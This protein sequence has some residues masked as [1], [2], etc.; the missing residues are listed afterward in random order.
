MSFHAYQIFL[1]S[2]LYDSN[3]TRVQMLSS[4]TKTN[5][6]H[7]RTVLFYELTGLIE[8]LIEIKEIIEY[9]NSKD[10]FI[11]PKNIKILTNKNVV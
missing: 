5:K 7:D 6:T 8:I 4:S 11:L 3:A 1:V 2:A 9:L 10:F